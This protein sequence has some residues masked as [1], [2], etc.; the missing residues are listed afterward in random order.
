[1][2]TSAKSGLFLANL[3]LLK[4]PISHF[5]FYRPQMG[6]NEKVL[7]ISFRRTPKTRDSISITKN[8]VI[9][10]R[11]NDVAQ[12]Q[13]PLNVWGGIFIRAVHLLLSFDRSM[14]GTNRLQSRP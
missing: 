3:V 10:V 12:G 9:L 1:M 7:A 8:M 2:Q 14:S 13:I 6:H 5:A 4:L 11:K